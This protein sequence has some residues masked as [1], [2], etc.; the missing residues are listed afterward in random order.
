MKKFLFAF[1][2]FISVAEMKI[3]F[4][5]T[6]HPFPDTLAQWS[7]GSIYYGMCCSGL[8]FMYAEAGDT[9]INNT[10]YTLVGFNLTYSWDTYWSQQYENF[11]FQIPGEI[12]GAIREDTLRKI[13]FRNFHPNMGWNYCGVDVLPIDTDLLLY[14]FNI[15][16]GDTA[17]WIQSSSLQV[18]QKIDSIQLMDGTWRRVFEFD[19]SNISYERNWIEGIGSLSGLFGP[20]QQDFFE[21][22]CSLHCFQ[23]ADT[24][25]Y[26]MVWFPQ[27]D[28]NHIYTAVSEP[29][30]ANEVF[31]FPNPATDFVTFD[32]TNVPNE[33]LKLTIYNSNGQQLNQYNNLH[34][35]WLTIPVSQLGAD[36]LYF[37][38][39][40]IDDKKLFA[41]KF[42]IQR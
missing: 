30:N 28:C 23:Q 31:E 27:Y 32:L 18:L 42:L 4:G 36:G 14:D 1:L 33:K 41:G 8:G 3:S 22:G 21:N 15:H 16:V 26:E 39:V 19:S 6:Y 20:Y 29:G 25:L 35:D 17:H 11:S 2:L 38:T 37:Y 9:T 24:M 13:W 40:R 34:T 7:E 10:V 5:Q 12:F